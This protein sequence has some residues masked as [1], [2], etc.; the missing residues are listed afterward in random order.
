M[1]KTKEKSIG[2]LGAG[3]FGTALAF[4]YRLDFNVT[5]FSCFA[6]HVTSM[7]RTRE[8]KFF[9]GFKIPEDIVIDTTSNLDAQQY[10]YLFWVFPIKPTADILRTL[11]TSMKTTPVIICSKGLLQD[12][13][14][15]SN[16]FQKTLASSEIGYLAGP[17][18]AVE[19]AN[20]KLSLADVAAQNMKIAQVFANELSIQTFKLKATDDLIGLQI[21]GAIKNV[22]AIASGI[23]YGLDLGENA[24][25]ALLALG[26]S[27]MEKL[28][29]SLGAKKETFY[30]FCGLGD[31]IMTA[32]SSKSRNTSLGMELAQGK[33]IEGILN[34]STCEGYDTVSKIVEISHKNG[35]RLPICETVYKILFEAQSPN[36]ILDVFE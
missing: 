16:L 8:N 5:L 36:T 13:S 22:I 24:H 33:S 17:N 15:V 29:L 9:K 18:F 26:I 34:T 14:F 6:D 2:I 32:S 4:A 20:G 27:E 11:K 31:L 28:G 30:G 21:S 19:L 35:I 25:S 10:D 23:A 12:L 3:A 1:L 7:N